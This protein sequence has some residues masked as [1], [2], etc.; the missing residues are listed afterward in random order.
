MNPKLQGDLLIWPNIVKVFIMK[1]YI[2]LYKDHT[3]PIVIIIIVI[4]IKK[5]G[6]LPSESYIYFTQ[7]F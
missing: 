4:L 6:L 3:L 7:P 1:K 5:I 2:P